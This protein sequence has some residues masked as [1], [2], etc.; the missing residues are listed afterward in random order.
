[1][2]DTEARAYGIA[3]PSLGE[4]FEWMEE[5]LQLALRM[6]EGDASPF[7]GRHLHLERPLNHPTSI[8]RPHPP[9]LVGGAGEKKT[10]RI[11]AQYADACNVFDIPDGG[12]TVKRK[13]DV[14]RRHCEA[15]GRDYDEI[16]KTLSTRYVPG[17]SGA[18]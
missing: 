8:R 16:E 12:V 17:E 14:L 9:I 11:V 10:L 15:V 5:T 7:H 13:L 6:W 18:E 3:S 2:D 1:A 4:R